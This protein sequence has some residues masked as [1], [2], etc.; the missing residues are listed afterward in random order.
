MIL[1]LESVF[2]AVGGFLFRHERLGA[3]ELLGCVLVF[4]STIVAQSSA[5]IKEKKVED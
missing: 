2:A 4:A 3:M 5:F 1:S